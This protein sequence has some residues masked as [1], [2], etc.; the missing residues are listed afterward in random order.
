MPDGRRLRR[1]DARVHWNTGCAPQKRNATKKATGIKRNK[2]N[3]A[4]P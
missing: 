4:Q 2:A 3:E 1:S